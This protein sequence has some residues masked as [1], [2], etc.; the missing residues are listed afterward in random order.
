MEVA[1]WP[2]LGTPLGIVNEI[3]P[4]GVFPK[5]VKEEAWGE[6]HKY[7]SYE[8]AKIAA[9]ELFRREVDMGFAQWSLSR[10]ELEQ[11]WNPRAL[12]HWIH[13]KDEARWHSEGEA[14][15]RLAE[16]HGEQPHRAAGETS[17]AKVEGC[18]GRRV[19]PARN[20]PPR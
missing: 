10:L 16:E 17:S 7:K 6:S 13:F 14:G 9:D 5:V 19:A 4:G 8:E 1:T 20:S 15:P 2:T 18:N 11:K 12:C 3:P